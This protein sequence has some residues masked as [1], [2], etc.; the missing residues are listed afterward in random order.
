MAGRTPFLS[1][2]PAPMPSC[3]PLRWLAVT[4]FSVLAAPSPAQVPTGPVPLTFV[5]NQGQWDTDARFVLRHRSFAA[6]FHDSAIVLQRERQGD[7]PLG[8]AVRFS[9]ENAR[10]VAPNVEGVGTARASSFVGSRDRWRSGL[11]AG[12]RLRYTALWPG[13]DLLVRDHGGEIEY[14]FELAPGADLSKVVIRCE[15][16][17][18]LRLDQAGGLVVETPLGDLQ[19]RPPVTWE[20]GASGSRRPLASRFVM[21]SDDSFGF[22]VDGR[23]PTQALVVDPVI[24]W[25]T[26]FGATGDDLIFGIDVAANGDTLVVG[27]TSSLF[28]F[29]ATPG[30]YEPTFQGGLEDGF[31]ARLTASVGGNAQLLWCTFFGGSGNDQIHRVDEGPAGQI[32]FVGNTVST[33]IPT[34]PGALQASPAGARDSFVGVLNANGSTL[35]TSTYIGGTGDDFL[36][37]VIIESDGRVLV[38]GYVTAGGLP[39]S[40][41]AFQSVFAGGSYDGWVGRIDPATSGAAQLAWGTYFG[42][43]QDDVFYQLA[44]SP[45]LPGL[46]TCVGYTTQMAGPISGFRGGSG[47]AADG[48]IA[49]FDPAAAGVAQKRMSHFL[50]NNGNDYIYAAALEVNGDI[51]VTGFTSGAFPVTAGSFRT[52]SGQDG[53]IAKI[54]FDGRSI[55]YA[56]YLGS[57]NTGNSVNVSPGNLFLGADGTVTV[58]GYTSWSV[59]LTA[60]AIDRTRAG[61]YENFVMRLNAPL[62]QLLFSTYQGGAGDDVCAFGGAHVAGDV[63]TMSCYTTSGGLPIENPYQGSH[64]GGTYDGYLFRFDMVANPNGGAGLPSYLSATQAVGSAPAAVAIADIDGDSDP[65]ILTANAGSNDA[66]LLRNLGGGTFTG[67]PATIPLGAGST[68]PTGIAVGDLD[69][70][71]VRDDAAITCATSNSI[72]IVR[73][74]S[75][76]PIPSTRASTGVRPR[77]LVA[78]ALDGAVTD[79]LVVGLE[80]DAIG[81]GSGLEISRNGGAFVALTIPAGRSTRVVRVAVADLDG[82]GDRDVVALAQGGS[83]EVHLWAGDGAGALTFAGFLPMASQLGMGAGLCVGDLDVDGDLDIA[84]V[85]PVLT[86]P[87]QTAR[88]FRRTTPGPLAAANY[89]ADSDQLIAGTIALAAAC[90]DLDQDYIPGFG[91]GPDLVVVSGGSGTV[92]VNYG[93]QA[94]SG[95]FGAAGPV[96]SGAGPVDVALADLDGSTTTDIVIVNRAS[97]S[98]TIHLTDGALARPFGT[99]CAGFNGQVPRIGASG[100]PRLGSTSS[101]QVTLAR[102]TS[103]AVLAFALTS[104][105][106]VLG[107]GCSFY[108]GSP[109]AT[110]FSITDASGV[111]AS[112]IVIPNTLS[113]VGVDA[114]FQWA[115]FDSAGAYQSAIAFSNGLRIQVGR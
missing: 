62:T 76:T 100:L 57:G 33:D 31:V 106:T 51:A 22:A 55:R 8:V 101:V 91:G 81:G 80:G 89:A 38:C 66:T 32:A 97:N 102:A 112:P 7:A 50:G 109:T 53:F 11:R 18:G 54:T 72:A 49:Q 13:V 3:P 73:N 63:V 105:T 68:G 12:S 25:A 96:P 78:G 17:S 74:V 61:F 40:Q 4:A 70:D 10:A 103:P 19:Q 36:N 56:T 44:V 5:E 52:T 1:P 77:H 115:I 30:S 98:V 14:D 85:Q 86:P 107:G 29:P 16:G 92:D 20:I 15:G 83:D 94:Q 9:F 111:A 37:D 28:T 79:D 64:Q 39:I 23:D 113:L 59:P 42:A 88:V 71:G 108:M 82:D 110:R 114:F 90:A 95:N 21:K 24:L 45:V 34:T 69:G 41:G 47:D 60:G 48:M 26:Y 75:G 84:V 2:G 27:R 58:I 6:R 93:F 99:G 67:L 87:G 35:L 65:D 46:V 104:A 43:G